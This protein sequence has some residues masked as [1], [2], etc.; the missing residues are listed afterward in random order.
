MGSLGPM[1]HSDFVTDRTV[2][3][4]QD[5]ERVRTCEDLDTFTRSLLPSLNLRFFSFYEPDKTKGGQIG[6]IHLHNIPQEWLDRYLQMGYDAVSPVLRKI[7]R[8]RAP[9]SWSTL[10]PEGYLSSKRSRQMFGESGEAGLREGFSHP[11]LLGD[12]HMVT[13]NFAAE[14]LDDDP[15]VEPTLKLVALCLHER[16]RALRGEDCDKPIPQLSKQ[17][18]EC[19]RWAA[20]GKTNWEISEIVRISESSVR[21]YIDRAK[22]KLGVTTRAQAF[23]LGTRYGIIRN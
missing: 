18:R 16:F 14:R 20:D 12:G 21:T 19:L 4:I 1:I 22:H 2:R 7:T 10:G 3:L 23:V 17:E 8:T 13:I 15:R 5:L 11:I 9:F 6:G